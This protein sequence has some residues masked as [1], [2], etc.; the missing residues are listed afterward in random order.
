MGGI[1]N[2]LD[3][4]KVHKWYEQILNEAVKTVIVLD[5]HCFLLFFTRAIFNYIFIFQQ[6]A[7]N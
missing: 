7:L 1:G 4:A 6:I 5:F 3:G 2:D